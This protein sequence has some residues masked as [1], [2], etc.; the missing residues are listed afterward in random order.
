[1]Q[2]AAT[3]PG[4]RKEH[5]DEAKTLEEGQPPLPRTQDWN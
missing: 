5:K 4:W 1:M 3:T 2:E